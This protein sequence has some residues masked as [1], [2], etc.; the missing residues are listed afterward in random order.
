MEIILG[1]LARI[2]PGEGRTFNTSGERVT[3]FRTRGGELFAVQASC[4]HRGG[5]LA[6]GILGAAK[7]ICPLHA[8]TFDLRTG[9]ALLGESNLT[10]YHVRLNDD[11]EV[12][13]SL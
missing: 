3:V 1:P 9:Q 5:P 12:V 11:Q 8:W 13:L 4:P 6:D 10:T 7:L 2:P